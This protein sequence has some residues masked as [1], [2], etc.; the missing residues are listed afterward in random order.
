MPA[1][2]ATLRIWLRLHDEMTLRA[3]FIPPNR[4]QSRRGHIDQFGDTD[5]L[6]LDGRTGGLSRSMTGE[7]DVVPNAPMRNLFAPNNF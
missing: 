4:H 3:M 5:H 1:A 2:E 6:C 7:S